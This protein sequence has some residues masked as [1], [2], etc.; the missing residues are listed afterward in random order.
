[1]IKKDI[2]VCIIWAE[3]ICSYEQ[4]PALAPFKLKCPVENYLNWTASARVL[5]S[6]SDIVIVMVDGIM[7]HIKM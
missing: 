4:L 7:I 2:C 1:M 5:V 6:V 3:E